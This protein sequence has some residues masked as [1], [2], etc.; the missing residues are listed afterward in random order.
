[1]RDHGPTTRPFRAIRLSAGL[2]IRLVLLSGVA[3]AA[4]R[5]SGH[6]Q[7]QM[8]HV[9]LRVDKSIVFLIDNLRG[10]LFGSIP[11]KLPTFDDKSS[12]RTQRRGDFCFLADRDVP[13]DSKM[14]VIDGRCFHY[15]GNVQ[16]SRG[17][18]RSWE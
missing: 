18:I 17:R 14:P 10:E 11:A 6:T 1:M 4:D 12:I 7:V 5:A 13:N 2:L 3:T 15:R 8:R 9:A 16:Y